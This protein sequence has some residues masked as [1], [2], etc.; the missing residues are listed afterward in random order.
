MLVVKAFPFTVLLLAW[1]AA[2]IPS[3]GTTTITRTRAMQDVTTS[4]VIAMRT[5]EVFVI[6]PKTVDSVVTTTSVDAVFST[7]TTTVP[8]S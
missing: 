8:S 6:V 1:S 3:P 5:S 4:T 2:T 7:T